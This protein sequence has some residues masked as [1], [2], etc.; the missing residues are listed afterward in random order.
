MNWTNIIIYGSIAFISI[1]FWYA[2]VFHV[3]DWIAE[4]F[5]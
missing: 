4:W 1:A 2:I 5:K 3:M